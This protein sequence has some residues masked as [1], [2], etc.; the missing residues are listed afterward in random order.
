MSKLM[1]MFDRLAGLRGKHDKLMATQL[2]GLSQGQFKALF[3]AI[4]TNK[5][6]QEALLREMM[7]QTKEWD[8]L[9]A[10]IGRQVVRKKKAKKK[11]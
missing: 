2:S 1:S 11:S 6:K 9:L 8:E 5:A 7:A 10:L 4:D 3:K